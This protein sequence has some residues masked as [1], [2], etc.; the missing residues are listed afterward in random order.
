MTNYHITTNTAYDSREI[1]FDGI[2]S[3]EVRTALKSLKMRWNPKRSIWYGFAQESELISAILAA[4]EIKPADEAST[5]Y[6]DGYMG[7]GAVYGSKSNQ[8]LFG[9]DLTK[10]IRE[11]IKKAGIKGVTIRSKSY[12]GGQTITAT[13]SLPESA[14]VP[15]ADFIAN[16]EINYHQSWI[17]YADSCGKVQSVHIEKYFDSDAETRNAIK[18]SAAMY[19]YDSTTRHECPVSQHYIDTYKSFTDETRQLLK[20][21]VSIIEAYRYDESNA[22][23]DYFNTNFYFGI[24]TKPAK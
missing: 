17:Y 21:I 14:F 8:Y 10:A 12:S 11:D 7:G 16:Y 2:P 24:V 15:E 1:S 5:V 9:A 13:V 3:E 4:D 18:N 22:M 23:V 19:E 20:K 6:T